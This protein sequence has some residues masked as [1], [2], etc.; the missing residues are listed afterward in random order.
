MFSSSPYIYHTGVDL[1][2][3]LTQIM[4]NQH[5]GTT[6]VCTVLITACKKHKTR[7]SNLQWSLGFTKAHYVITEYQ[8]LH[9]IFLNFCFDMSLYSKTYFWGDYVVVLKMVQVPLIYHNAIPIQFPL[10][11]IQTNIAALILWT[12]LLHWRGI[13]KPL[14][15]LSHGRVNTLFDIYLSFSV[16]ATYPEC[17]HSHLYWS[18]SPG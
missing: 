13:T 6:T 17:C 18:R 10:L 11:H 1:W 12:I 14:P 8:F 3:I 5:T 7:H 16:P 9:I 15:F 2:H 4:F